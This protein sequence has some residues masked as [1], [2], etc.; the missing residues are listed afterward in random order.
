MSDLQVQDDG[1]G[2]PAVWLPVDLTG[3]G[4]KTLSASPSSRRLLSLS[5]S[6]GT[7]GEAAQAPLPAPSSPA[8]DAPA[9]SL[10]S[11]VQA[12]GDDAS[13]SAAGPA[14]GPT[15]TLQ[16]QQRKRLPTRWLELHPPAEVL[17]CNN[18]QEQNVTEAACGA[19][20]DVATLHVNAS[21]A[22]WLPK[23]RTG[24]V[25]VA[26]AA[27]VRVTP[28]P[29]LLL[30][31]NMSCLEGTPVHIDLM[32]KLLL[33]PV[34]KELLCAQ[35]LETSVQCACLAGVRSPVS[36]AGADR[37]CRHSAAAAAA[38]HEEQDPL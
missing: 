3:I 27:Q 12:S 10:G 34:A 2:V 4:N 35:R 28:M 17:A 9:S 29:Q 18:T 15:P 6:T 38:E 23:A 32:F 7:A 16:S 24:G 36:Y 5:P 26:D 19:R 21:S 20:F 14:V 22:P 37:A 25:F 11:A 30:C 31:A 8:A 33:K 1:K 13:S